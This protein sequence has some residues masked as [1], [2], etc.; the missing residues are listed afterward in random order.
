MEA[1]VN[2]LQQIADALFSTGAD[3]QGAVVI[4]WQWLTS[5]TVLP[6]FLIGV[7]VSML[8]LAVRIVKGIFWGV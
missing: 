6:Y 5:A 2:V 3:S 8:L 7:G 1:I 4:F